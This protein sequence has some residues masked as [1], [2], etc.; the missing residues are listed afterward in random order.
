MTEFQTHDLQN[1]SS[2]FN[3]FSYAIRHR[4]VKLKEYE[5]TGIF[6]VYFIRK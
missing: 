6:I 1:K 3:I 4:N 2:Q 5:V